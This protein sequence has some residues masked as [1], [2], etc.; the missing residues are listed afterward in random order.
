MMWVLW[1]FIAI[2]TGVF[3]YATIDNDQIPEEWSWLRK[4]EFVTEQVQTSTGSGYAGAPIVIGGWA[5]SEQPVPAITKNMMTTV[6]DESGAVLGVPSISLVCFKNKVFVQL[7]SIV[8]LKFVDGES[9]ILVGDVG[10]PWTQGENP[11]ISFALPESKSLDKLMLEK[12]H[13]IRMNL[14]GVGPTQFEFDSSGVIEARRL[15]P[16]T[17]H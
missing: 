7:N 9:V 3:I 6:Y 8:P 12:A 5:Y 14:K 13:Q 2:I 1:S 4:N 17:C 16:S 10:E 15:L 11:T